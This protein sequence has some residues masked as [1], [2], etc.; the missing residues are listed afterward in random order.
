MSANPVLDVIDVQPK[1][2]EQTRDFYAEEARAAGLNEK[3]IDVWAETMTD[4]AR[5]LRH[6]KTE[7]H[8]R[9]WINHYEGWVAQMYAAIHDIPHLEAYH[10]LADTDG[11]V[12][13]EKDRSRPI[14]KLEEMYST[15]ELDKLVAIGKQSEAELAA[16]QEWER[17]Q[18]IRP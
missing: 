1:E 6:A 11:F 17:E 3:E 4:I 2:V 13:P 12:V 7:A 18:G 5:A 9:S 14:A 10:Y 15:E 8:A 16:L